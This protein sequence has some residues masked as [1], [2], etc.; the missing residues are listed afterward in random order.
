M[1]KTP[2]SSPGLKSW[3]ILLLLSFVWGSSFI[4][5]KK[6]LIAF[7]PVE[8]GALR[9]FITFL[10]FLPV[11]YYHRKKINWGD[12]KKFLAVGIMGSAL[13]SVLFAIAQT[14]VSSSIAGVLN[15]ITPVFTLIIGVIL[16][17]QKTK[18]NQVIGVAFGFIGA[19]LL[20][21][22]DQSNDTSSNLFYGM[23]VVLATI[24]Y[25]YNVNA[26]KAWVENT[27]PI[28]ISAVSFS[29]LGP[30]GALYLFSTTFIE[31]LTTNEYG[32][33]SLGAVLF[34]A[35]VGTAL[36]TI[37]FF[38]LIQDTDAIFGSSVAFVIPIFAV[39]W[40][41]FDGESFYLIQVLGMLLVLLGIYLIRD[42]KKKK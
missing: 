38:K 11:I 30:L 24:C 23:L 35:L 31:H 42:K 16:F 6:S 15:S 26:I 17:K 1:E 2:Q 36:S 22:G 18:K 19:L 3:I 41:L 13:P 25:A 29:M 7:D 4:L 28:I 32:W 33:Y 5:I 14:E 10:A 9:V 34:L 37:L 8:V 40:G 27:S 39:L 20:L 12:W 21:L